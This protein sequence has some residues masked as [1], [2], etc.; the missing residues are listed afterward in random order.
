M[1]PLQRKHMRETW[2]AAVALRNR[3][4]LTVAE[5]TKTFTAMF[6]RQNRELLTEEA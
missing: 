4:H 3:K 6:I 5:V 1:T 2:N